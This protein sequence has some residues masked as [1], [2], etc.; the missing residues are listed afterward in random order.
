MGATKIFIRRA[1]DVQALE[2]ARISRQERLITA[3]QAY[4]RAKIYRKRFLQKRACAIGIQAT[5]RRLLAQ[6]YAHKRRATIKLL[7]DYARV[8]AARVYFLKWRRAIR[9]MQRHTRFWI[10]RGRCRKHIGLMIRIQVRSRSSSSLFLYYVMCT[11][12][13]PIFWRA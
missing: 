3:L 12:R 2:A 6:R 5:M 9:T 10:L 11:F 13:S 8:K 4:Q 1:A 7:Q